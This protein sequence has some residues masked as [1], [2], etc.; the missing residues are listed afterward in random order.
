MFER[1]QVLIDRARRLVAK[2]PADCRWMLV[3]TDDS[4]E[5]EDP[6]SASLSITVPPSH[7][8]AKLERVLEELAPSLGGGFSPQD[9]GAW[10]K[11]EG[12]L[13]VSVEEGQ[14]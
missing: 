11:T 4:G 2:L 12:C 8:D 3:V 13:E 5:G 9:D 14:Q 1:Q 6:L 10:E 7:M